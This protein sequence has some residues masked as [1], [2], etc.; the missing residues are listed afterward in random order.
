MPTGFQKRPAAAQGPW[1]TLSQNGYGIR[2][3]RRQSVREK[4]RLSPLSRLAAPGAKKAGST[5]RS[6]QAVP[7]PSTNRALLRLTSEFG[8]DLVY[9]QWYGRQRDIR[10]ALGKVLGRA[11]RGKKGESKN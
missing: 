5:R 8:R 2:E 9:S 10:A 11:W 1:G 3:L 4:S 6:S 7:H